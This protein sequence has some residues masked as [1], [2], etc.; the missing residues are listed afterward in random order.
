MGKDSEN[1]KDKS[2]ELVKA[3]SLI[4]CSQNY[5]NTDVCPGVHEKKWEARKVF[6]GKQDEMQSLPGP[7][8]IPKSSGEDEADRNNPR[9]GKGTLRALAPR[10]EG[11]RDGVPLEHRKLVGWEAVIWCV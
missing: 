4:D 6:S 7:S 8:Q 3:R 1:Q 10:L 5:H 2:Q 9:W 11:C